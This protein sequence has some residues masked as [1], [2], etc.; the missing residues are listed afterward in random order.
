MENNSTKK[1][2]IYLLISN[3]TQLLFEALFICVVVFLWGLFTFLNSS[4]ENS[5]AYFTIT[6]E[7]TS[8]LEVAGWLFRKL[9]L[10]DIY[11][12]L[13]IRPIGYP[14]LIGVLFKFGAVSML[15]VQ[16]ALWFVAQRAIFSIIFEKT[17]N[18]I[19]ALIGTVI[20][21]T[22]IAHLLMTH[23][24][25][26]EALNLPLIAASLFFVHR[27]VLT[28]KFNYGAVSIFFLALNSIVRP[29]ESYVFMIV[30]LFFLINYRKSLVKII[31]IILCTAPVIL[32]LTLMILVFDIASLSIND[33]RTIDL[34]LLSRVD[35]QQ[36]NNSIQITRLLRQ[37][38]SCMKIFT[39]KNP[40]EIKK[41]KTCVNNQLKEYLTTE[42]VAT[43]KALIFNMHKNMQE[44]TTFVSEKSL[45]L[46]KI[47]SLQNVILCYAGLV[48]SLI[49]FG[50]ILLKLS[51]KKIN[52]FNEIGYELF[53]ILTIVIH[54]LQC[55]VSFWQGDRLTLGVYQP[56]ILLTLFAGREILMHY[57]LAGLFKLNS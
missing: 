24:L 41:Y 48:I 52:N 16:V 19:F 25:L 27:Y 56:T 21:V 44:E 33:S 53:L 26:S 30:L 9:S 38:S 8:Y 20:S 10:Q 28:N 50:Y 32:Q 47:S 18:I 54:L 17:N 37:N 22:C 23:Y 40:D 3:R 31:I 29:A 1:A 42:P 6:S 12:S 43:L 2:P 7:A 34:F 45:I 39:D 55:G 13:S 46:Y 11:Y 14:L 57:K 4:G 15:V 35:S 36:T 49:Y 51:N 5:L